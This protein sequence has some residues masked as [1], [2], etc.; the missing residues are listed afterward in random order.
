M[1]LFGRR[2]EVPDMQWWPWP[3]LTG[4]SPKS[5]VPPPQRHHS[6]DQHHRHQPEKHHPGN[7]EL[8]G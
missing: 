6:P 2:R 5:S 8:A 4:R 1:G 7:L 3:P